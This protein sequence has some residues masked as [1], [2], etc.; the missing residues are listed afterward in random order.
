MGGHPAARR[1]WRDYFASIDGIVFMVDAVEF[2]RFPEACNE[3]AALLTEESIK[4]VPF[5]IL[6]NKVP[7]SRPVPLA[8][9]HS[10]GSRLSVVFLRL[11]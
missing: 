9:A 8:L 7:A 2:E 4:T 5:L 1:L 6:G 3:L 10:R 11:T